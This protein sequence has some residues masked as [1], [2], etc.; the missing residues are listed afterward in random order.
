M[1]YTPVSTVTPA[2]V[3]LRMQAGATFYPAFILGG[4]TPLDLTGFHFRMQVFDL[5]G[6][7]AYDLADAT[8]PDYPTLAGS[9]GTGT[10]LTPADGLA[11]GTIQ[12]VLDPSTTALAAGQQQLTYKVLVKTPAELDTPSPTPVW[13]EWFTG[14]IQVG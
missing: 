12:P 1:P 6:R 8:S 3:P 11:A 13:D 2:N 4:S 5:A 10:I 9:L 14:K 7:L